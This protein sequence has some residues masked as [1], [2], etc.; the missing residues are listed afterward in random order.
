MSEAILSRVVVEIPG[1]PTER[2]SPEYLMHQ[3]VTSLFRDAPEARPIHRVL[4]EEGPCATLMVLSRAAPRR[5]AAI[6]P[7]TWVRDVSSKSFAPALEAGQ[8]LDFDLIANATAVV[9]QPDGRKRRTD[10]WDAAFAGEG[11]LSADR[12]AVYA[13]WLARQ[14]DGA[15]EFERVEVAA[16][17]FVRIR[18]PGS[19]PSVAFVR[20]QLV[21]TLRVADPSTLRAL[22][23]TGIGRARAFGCGLL[24]L[25][26]HG[27]LPRRR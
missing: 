14:C 7:G 12:S 27:H 22:V 25:L 13:A 1:G 18:K 8:L 6:A 23:S 5:T 26:P 11:R 2:V 24:C 4:Q 16:R 21:G 9:T 10:V 17:G 15:A 20:T 3:A 19:G